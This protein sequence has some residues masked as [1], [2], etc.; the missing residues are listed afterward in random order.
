MTFHYSSGGQILSKAF[1]ATHYLAELPTLPASA[2]TLPSG[3]LPSLSLQTPATPLFK[4]FSC[5]KLIT[6][7]S[8][9]CMFCSS[10][11][12]SSL[13]QPKTTMC[14]VQHNHP[15]SGKPSPMLHVYTACLLYIIQLDNQL[16]IYGLIYS[17]LPDDKICEVRTPSSPG[18]KKEGL[19]PNKYVIST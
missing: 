13:A 16:F 8:P 10:S 3:T 19:L 7:S 5:T 4:F 11:P 2:G 9:V 14:N 17:S 1:K 15:S 12:T 18:P 6:S